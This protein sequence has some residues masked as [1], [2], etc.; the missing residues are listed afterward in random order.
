MEGALSCVFAV[1][2]TVVCPATTRSKTAARLGVHDVFVNVDV[3][4][5]RSRVSA[6]LLCGSGPSAN[7]IDESNARFFESVTDVWSTNQFFVHRHLTPRFHHAEF[8]KGT[9]DFWRENYR[10]SARFRETTFILDDSYTEAILFLLKHDAHVFAYRN[11]MV[12]WRSRKSCTPADGY[13]L[14]SPCK[15]LRKACSASTTLVLNLLGLVGYESVYFVGI[16]LATPKHFWTENPQYPPAL[17]RYQ[18]MVNFRG[19]VNYSDVLA[20]G[21][22]PTRHREVHKFIEGFVAYNGIR[23]FNLSPIS[24]DLLALPRVSIPDIVSR[25]S[26]QVNV[27]A[28]SCLGTARKRFVRAP[29]TDHRPWRTRR[30]VE[31][32]PRRIEAHVAPATLTGPFRVPPVLHSAAWRG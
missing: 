9:L 29:S 11:R 16:D 13:F 31:G 5:G 3:L 21:V 15:R 2:A 22:H 17:S 4:R 19:I 7:L 8:K 18:P 24:A 6:A 14:P 25:C 1:Q 10:E 12:E 23:G 32:S 28:S 20:S 27:T 30:Q 26:F